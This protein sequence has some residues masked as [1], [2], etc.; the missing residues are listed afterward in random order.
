MYS[1]LSNFKLS[2][3]QFHNQQ[4]YDLFVPTSTP[5]LKY[6]ETTISD[7]YVSIDSLMDFLKI[8]KVIQNHIQPGAKL[9]FKF[10]LERKTTEWY[11]Q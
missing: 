4:Y 7:N 8:L 3:F 1:S 6:K 10:L 9:K 5:L 11:G 2:A